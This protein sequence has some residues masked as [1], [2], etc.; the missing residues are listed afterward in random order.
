[1]FSQLVAARASQTVD[2]V[3]SKMLPSR[4]NGFASPP[5][6]FASAEWLLG[7]SFFGQRWRLDLL[8]GRGNVGYSNRNSSYQ[9]IALSTKEATDASDRFRQLKPALK[10]RPHEPHIRYFM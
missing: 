2:L 7:K 4:G 1:M 3:V 6:C 10:Q 9:G 5:V 8:Q